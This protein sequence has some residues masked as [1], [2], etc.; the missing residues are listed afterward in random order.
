M[1]AAPCCL[2]I[3]STPFSLGAMHGRIRLPPKALKTIG[4]LSLLV[5]LIF[6]K[7]ALPQLFQH[8]WSDTND[9][10]NNRKAEA[11]ASLMTSKL[12][13]VEAQRFWLN[14]FLTSNISTPFSEIKL[15]LCATASHESRWLLEWLVYHRLIGIEHIFMYDSDV[16][17]ATL[18]VLAPFIQAG[19]VTLHSVNHSDP[20]SF[21]TLE[22]HHCHK[23]YIE[24]ADWLGHWDVDEFVYFDKTQNT[25]PMQLPNDKWWF[26]LHAAVNELGNLRR[27][28]GGLVCVGITTST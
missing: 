22:L 24:T 26:P 23:T 14:S 18:S 6:L 4:V 8:P 16:D 12:T 20:K 15:A 10:P 13:A 9:F 28:V 11:S 1:K 3:F 2:I 17:D 27:E 5:A 21:Q 7:V 19:Y 25:N